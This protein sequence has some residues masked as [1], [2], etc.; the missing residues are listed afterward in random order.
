MIDEHE[1]LASRTSPS[2]ICHVIDSPA[3]S[4]A[5]PEQDPKTT[6][7]SD[8]AATKAQASLDHFKAVTGMFDGLKKD[9]RRKMTQKYQV[10]F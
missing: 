6:S 4:E 3:P 1:E 2:R 10:E 9:M 8:P 7:P 5:A